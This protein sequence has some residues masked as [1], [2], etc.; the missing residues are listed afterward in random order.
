MKMIDRLIEGID[1][2]QTPLTVGIDL[3]IKEIYKVAPELVKNILHSNSSDFDTVA[4]CFWKYGSKKIDEIYDLVPGLKLQMAFYE[5]Y[6]DTAVELAFVGLK[7]YAREKGLIDT[8]DA[9]RG[10]TEN[11]SKMYAK[12]HL[13]KLLHPYF[14]DFDTEEIGF[15]EIP[16]LDV[17]FLTVNPYM[18]HDC[19]EPFVEQCRI[20]DKGIFILVKTSNPGSE[21]YQDRLVLVEEPE[22]EILESLSIDL[23]DDLYTPLYN[24][25]A[26]D[27]RKYAS[28]PVLIGNNGYSNIGAV[29]GATVEEKIIKDLRKIMPDSFF[30]MPGAGSSQGGSVNNAMEAFD[31]NGLGAILPY[32]RDLIDRTDTRDKAIE[33]IKEIKAEM[34]IAGKLPKGWKI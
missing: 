10:D 29:V 6:Y 34:K 28:D 22:K 3:N 2:K 13:G 16:A 30:L 21:D 15:K 4:Q 23:I 11:T 33:I 32:S 12:A 27:V 19:L 8:E 1:K 9:K 24:L 26:L 25:V 17:D 20:N 31:K 14:I 5:G 7:E 18:G